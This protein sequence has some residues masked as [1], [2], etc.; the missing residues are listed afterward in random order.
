MSVFAKSLFTALTSLFDVGSDLINS[1][2]FL[3][4][5]A[6]TDLSNKIYDTIT[7]IARNDTPS[8]VEDGFQSNGNDNVEYNV[9]ETW[10]Y[11]GI[12]IIFLPGIIFLHALY[13][14]RKQKSLFIAGILLVPIYPVF[15]LLVQLLGIFTSCSSSNMSKKVQVFIALAVGLEAFFES[16]CQIVLQIF[17]IIYGYPVTTVQIITILA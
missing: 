12:G 17:T 4:Y 5:N 6:S 8:C 1:F 15:M 7:S 16:F 10:G 3:G 9:H 2:D 14:V 11:V 13:Y